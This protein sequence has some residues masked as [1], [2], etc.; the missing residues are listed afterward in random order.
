MSSL[1]ISYQLQHAERSE[2][3]GVWGRI[4]QEVRWLTNRAFGP[5]CSD[6]GVGNLDCIC[7]TQGPAMGAPLQ[8]VSVVLVARA[9]SLMWNKPLVGG[10]S[11]YRTYWDEKRNY[12]GGK[13]SGA[14]CIRRKH[15]SDFS[16]T[17]LYFW[18]KTLDVAV[19]NCLNRFARTLKIPNET[20]SGV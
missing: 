9:I 4:P 15:S 14:L 13:P 12:G 6:K 5:E 2:K 11:L 8:S 10:Q 16:P 17:I 20:Q 19:G 18:Q 1:G 7:F 3:T